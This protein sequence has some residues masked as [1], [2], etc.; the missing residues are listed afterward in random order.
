MLS[1]LL[2]N[3]I[4]KL[5]FIMEIKL[6]KL[7]FEI[8]YVILQFF[9]KLWFNT[10]DWLKIQAEILLHQKVVRYILFMQLCNLKEA[11]FFVKFLFFFRINLLWCKLNF[12]NEFDNF[13]QLWRTNLFAL[14]FY[15]DLNCLNRRFKNFTERFI[16]LLI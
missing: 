2:C 4:F 10:W 6:E 8:N 3:H 9:Q 16:I 15:I 1:S 5:F 7:F 11:F 14:I 12:I 13:C